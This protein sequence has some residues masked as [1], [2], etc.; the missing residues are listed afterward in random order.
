MRNSFSKFIRYIFLTVFSPTT[1][2]DEC[3]RRALEPQDDIRALDDHEIK[4]CG[5][6]LDEAPIGPF[7]LDETNAHRAPLLS[8]PPTN[9]TAAQESTSAVIAAGA[10]SI[11]TGNTTEATV[12]THSHPVVVTQPVL[13]SSHVEP[14]SSSSTPSSGQ[15][16]IP[17]NPSSP[18][19][20]APVSPL[21]SPFQS[22]TRR[23]RSLSEISTSPPLLPPTADVSLPPGSD[24]PNNVVATPTRS[25]APP[26][27]RVSGRKRSAQ[28]PIS[29]RPAKRV[30]N[31]VPK[32]TDAAPTP[33]STSTLEAEV[34]NAAV[35]ALRTAYKWFAKAME[36]LNNDSLGKEWAELVAAWT[37]FEVKFE[38]TANGLL[39][40]SGRPTAV[41]DWIARGR[42]PKWRPKI[43]DSKLYGDA[44]DS[45]WVSL[46]P[47]WRVDDVGALGPVDGGSW[48][49]F[50]TSGANGLLSVVASLFFWG[51]A[52]KA[53]GKK[54]KRWSELV[55]DTTNVLHHLQ[56]A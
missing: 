25:P 46:Q 6:S 4:A 34:D 20:S 2:P 29:A 42:S 36:M 54:S 52:V 7:I 13:P 24:S 32:R 17:A 47:E 18:L 30:H 55:V 44:H 39:P 21:G 56:T 31:D 28:A 43:A 16:S 40:C 49:D 45:W 41:G 11:S 53:A 1:A 12:T 14:V 9:P 48:E 27:A 8:E 10:G 50:T 37:A 3:R 33:A 51:T 19:G 15:P 5:G 38:H 22:P 23:G 26:P 35:I